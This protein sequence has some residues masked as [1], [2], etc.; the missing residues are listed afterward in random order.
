MDVAKVLVDC[1]VTPEAT[2]KTFEVIG[3]AGYPAADSIA[4][5]LRN[6]RSDEQG[7]PPLDVIVSTYTTLQQLLP[8]E[9]QDAAALAM[10]Q[11][12]EQLDR[13]EVGR[14]GV[15]GQENAEAAA[16]KPSS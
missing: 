5:A 3:V 15:R 10:G 14:L 1:L 13:G 2:G 4:G 9:K 16:P 7:L 11:T 6:L 8:G 12:Y